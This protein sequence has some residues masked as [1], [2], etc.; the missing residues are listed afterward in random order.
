MTNNKTKL[1]IAAGQLI[2]SIQKEWNNEIGE[3]KAEV[4]M[5]VMDKAHDLLSGVKEN[6]L[7]IILNGLTVTQFLGETWV[8]KHKNVKQSILNFEAVLNESRAA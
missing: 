2:S 3:A 5:F 1:E 4:S 8:R 7:T 6:N